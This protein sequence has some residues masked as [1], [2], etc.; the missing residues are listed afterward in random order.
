VEGGVQRT[1]T[2]HR[3]AQLLFG[4]S[5]ITGKRGADLEEEVL[6]IAKSVGDS[7][8]DLDPIVDA[9][10]KTG[11]QPPAA[12]SEAS[13]LF[14]RA[15][16]EAQSL[17]SNPTVADSFC[18]G[19]PIPNRVAFMSGYDICIRTLPQVDGRSGRPE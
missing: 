2:L 18:F 12:M 11:A 5:G 4:S 17:A 9:L 10:Q 13:M 16:A 1:L 14:R 7:L 6:V 19:H 3:T 8:D 15:S